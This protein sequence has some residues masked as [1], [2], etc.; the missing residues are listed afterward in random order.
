MSSQ[1][2]V[3]FALQ[4][5]VMLACALFFGQLMRKVKQPAVVGEMFGGILLG[6]TLFGV[7]LPTLYLWLFHSSVS[8]G[9][10]RDASIKL[11]MLFFLFIAG[12]EVNL[13]DLRRLGRRAISI[14]LVGTLI[15]IAVGVALVYMLPPLF[16]VRQPVHIFSLSPCLWA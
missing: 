2:F 13:S 1:D 8:V 6:P 9:V 12:N 11:G 10:A 5:T 4:I 15:P 3:K 14:G 7:L 16:G